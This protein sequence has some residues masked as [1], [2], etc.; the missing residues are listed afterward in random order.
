MDNST[1]KSKQPFQPEDEV[2]L[3]ANHMD[4]LQ[5]ANATID[6]A[7][8]TTVYLV[9]FCPTTVGEIVRNYQWVTKSEFSRMIKP[10]CL[11]I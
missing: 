5:G 2:V 7:E 9:N 11:G 3:E 8:Q 4:G 1:K 10:V 6:L